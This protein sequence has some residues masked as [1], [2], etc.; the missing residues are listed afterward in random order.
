ML[1]ILDMS[2]IGHGCPNISIICQ[3]MDRHDIQR[4]IYIDNDSIYVYT[5]I[6]NYFMLINNIEQSG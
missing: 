3:T 1:S 4:K 6:N 2:L 5:V